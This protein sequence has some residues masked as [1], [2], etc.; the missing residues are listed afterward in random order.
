MIAKGVMMV[1]VIVLL[2]EMDINGRGT[3]RAQ[4]RTEVWQE[5]IHSLYNARG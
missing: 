4:D 3:S 2:D 1:V 5:V